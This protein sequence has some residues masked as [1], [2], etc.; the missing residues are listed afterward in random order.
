MT[1][2]HMLQLTSAG[3]MRVWNTLNQ[4]LVAELPLNLPP[5]TNYSFKV[6]VYDDETINYVAIAAGSVLQFY[7]FLLGAGFE[8][9]ME[10]VYNEPIQDIGF[11][12]ARANS[13][14]VVL[15][16]TGTFVYE[17]KSTDKDDESLV[18]SAMDAATYDSL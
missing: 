17:L 10:Q 18:F 3:W 6:A 1:N 15:T 2:V 5:Q 4:S 9:R 12:G 11:F 14:L 16:E 7:G 8:L 13:K